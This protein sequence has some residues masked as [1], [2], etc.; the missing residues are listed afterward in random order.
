MLR[1]LSSSIFA[2]VLFMVPQSLFAGGPPVLILP[3]D[4]VTSSN[5]QVCV[6]L[7]NAKLAD[8]IWDRGGGSPTARIVERKKQSYLSIDMNTDIALSHITAALKGSEFSIPQDRLHFFGHVIFEIGAGEASQQALLKELKSLPQ[9]SIEQSSSVNGLFQVT[10]DM[11]YPGDRGRGEL[12]TAGWET[13]Q[14][15]DFASDQSKRSEPPVA[16]DKLPRFDEI[17]KV[18]AKHDAKV[19]DVRWSNEYSCRPLGGVA[20]VSS[21]AKPVQVGSTNR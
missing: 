1:M 12:N 15:N 13:F 8:K 7:L 21:T 17:R 9:V 3:I 11:P 4:G 10:L 18:V 20:E 19:K 16:L 14:R 6:D 2:A 5:A